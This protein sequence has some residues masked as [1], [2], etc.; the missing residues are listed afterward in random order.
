MKTREF[1]E[2][3]DDGS[4]KGVEGHRWK[5]RMACTKGCQQCGSMR[6]Q[7]RKKTTEKESRKEGRR[8]WE[9]EKEKEGGR[10]RKEGKDGN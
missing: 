5:G 2:S 6:Q 7:R 1:W 4:T 8:C 9:K 3:H 10:G